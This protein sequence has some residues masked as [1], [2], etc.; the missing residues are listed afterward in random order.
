MKKKWE[1]FQRNLRIPEVTD[2]LLKRI[3]ASHRSE[4]DCWKKVLNSR[5]HRLVKERFFFL[6]STRGG[7]TNPGTQR[8]QSIFFLQKWRRGIHTYHQSFEPA[9]EMRQSYRGDE[10]THRYH[11]T[12]PRW[13]CSYSYSC[14]CWYVCKPLVDTHVCLRLFLLLP[15]SRLRHFSP[16]FCPSCFSKT[17]NPSRDRILS[18]SPSLSLID[19][20]ACSLHGWW[21]VFQSSSPLQQ[22]QKRW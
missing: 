15:I 16:F 3:S 19:W 2:R 14:S 4:K 6:K 10:Q 9:R 13:S 17:L 21:V 20:W 22:L 12:H 11:C 8:W 18:L 5:R 1:I 7:F